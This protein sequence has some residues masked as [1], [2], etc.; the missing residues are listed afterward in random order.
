[1]RRKLTIPIVIVL[2]A[3]AGAAWWFM[4]LRSGDGRLVLYGNIDLRQVQLAFNKS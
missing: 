3:V 4:T 1:M 2:I